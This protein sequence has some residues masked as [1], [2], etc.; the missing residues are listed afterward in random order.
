MKKKMISILII[1]FATLFTV[2]QERAPI[3][4]IESP[5][6][7]VKGVTLVNDLRMQS[8]IVNQVQFKEVVV[9]G[10]VGHSLYEFE[11]ILKKMNLNQAIINKGLDWMA[12]YLANP[13]IRGNWDPQFSLSP[14]RSGFQYD[15]QRMP[16]V[17]IDDQLMNDASIWLNFSNQGFMP[18]LGLAADTRIR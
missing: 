5:Y 15:Y 13:Q 1:G 9:S 3:T 8:T 12:F 7:L 10:K 4:K 18:A 16:A 11:N 2:G 14:T 17:I 6:R